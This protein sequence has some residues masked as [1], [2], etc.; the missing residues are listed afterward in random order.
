MALGTQH[1]D[2]ATCHTDGTGLG[3]VLEGG[4]WD[5]TCLTA[6]CH[7]LDSHLQNG[8]VDYSH[9]VA[10]S[11]T[12]LPGGCSAPA[13]SGLYGSTDYQRTACHYSDII[14][15]H[16]RK[17]ESGPNGTV[18]QTISVTCAQCH[19]SAQFEA[20]DGA[21]DGTCDACH[22]GTVLKNHSIAGTAEYTRVYGLHQ[23]PN[24]YSSGTN[25]SQGILIAGTNTMDAHGALRTAAAPAHPGA[26]KAIGCA[27]AFC[28]QNAYMKPGSGFYGATV[29]T[30]CHPANVAPAN[31]PSGTMTVNNGATFAASTA[32]TIDS[33]ITANGGAT[34]S[35]MAVDPG[36]GT[37]GT[38]VA[39]SASYAIT[40]P[41]T[42]GVKTVRVQYT[43][44]AAR[45]STY[46]YLIWRIVGPSTITASVSGGNG[47]VTPSGGISV[48]P[49][50]NQSFSFAPDPTYHVDTV[51]VDDSPVTNPGTG[52]TFT[53][54]TAPHAIVVTFAKDDPTQWKSGSY[55]DGSDYVTGLTLTLGSALPASSSLDFKTSYDIE[56]GWDYGY[57]QVS[58]DGGTTWTNTPGDITTDAD[59]NLAANSGVAVNQGNGITGTTAGSW[60]DAHFDLSAYQGQTIKIR[61]NYVCDSWTY[62]AG[63]N[64]SSIS[65][66][67]A[68]SPVFTDD[69]ST[70]KPE[71]SVASSRS[72]GWSR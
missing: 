72:P 59:P 44:S 64:I 13:G 60:V 19:D 11:L 17:I 14:Q 16:N 28:H 2:C 6:G 55:L 27:Q 4:K 62:G 66:G 51:T 37:Y 53:N 12:A 8:Q 31:A 33:A 32:A 42:P 35:S 26:Y 68:G 69:V 57:V 22:D 63:W 29:C 18:V 48:A 50:A 25:S 47:A 39:Y 65:V 36:T 5:K 45:I 7:T 10:A 56:D 9:K 23:A 1:S 40:L 41:G 21:W 38:P 61:F 58:A 15:E 49:A 70:L 30:Q 52:Y 54:V 24:Y 3:D 71:W 43:D 46:T 67:S 20:L 34:L